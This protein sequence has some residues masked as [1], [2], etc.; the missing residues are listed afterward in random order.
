MS[1][2]QMMLKG[3]LFRDNRMVIRQWSI[4]F[5]V[6]VALIVLLGKFVIPMWAAAMIGGFVTGAMMPYLFKDLK[7]N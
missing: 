6:A 2:A 1:S 5:L 4:G 7:Y 3:K